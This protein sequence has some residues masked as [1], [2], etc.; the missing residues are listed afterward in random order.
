[1]T[2]RCPFWMIVAFIGEI[3]AAV[4]ISF[5]VII[6]SSAFSGVIPVKAW[7][8]VVTPIIAIIAFGLSFWQFRK[9]NEDKAKKLLLLTPAYVVLSLLFAAVWG[10]LIPYILQQ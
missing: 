7:P 10:K 3:L 6:L 8:D 2:P 9:G 4:V 5:F 1:M